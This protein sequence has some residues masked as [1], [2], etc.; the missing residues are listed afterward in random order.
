V[1]LEELRIKRIYASKRVRV[2]V[3]DVRYVS[4]AAHFQSSC[5][6]KEWP[7][8]G[9]ASGA[10]KRINSQHPQANGLRLKELTFHHRP[11]HNHRRHLYHNLEFQYLPSSSR[12]PLYLTCTAGMFSQQM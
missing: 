9:Q 10:D 12:K 6:L 5:L 4:V 2:S 3:R 7:V 1:T 8:L 11:P